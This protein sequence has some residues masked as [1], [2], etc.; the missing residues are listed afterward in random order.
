MRRRI[1]AL[2]VPLMAV[3]ILVVM[4]GAGPAGANSYPGLYE[5][6]WTWSDANGNAYTLTARIAIEV[7]TAGN[8]GRFRLRLK[9]TRTD[10]VTGRTAPNNCL[11]EFEFGL[12]AWWCDSSP[13]WDCVTRELDNRGPS[14]EEVWVG[15]WHG[16]SN[17]VTYAVV[18][19]QF[20]AIFNGGA[21]HVGALHAICSYRWTKGGA[22]GSLYCPPS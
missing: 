22:T 9:C 14:S 19:R 5:K 10:A 7:T 21:G 11:F 6:D 20:R 15:T 3:P 16:L 2:L 13:S 4:L 8:E 17:G 1:A 12:N 18:A